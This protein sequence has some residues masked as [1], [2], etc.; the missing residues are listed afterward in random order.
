MDFYSVTVSAFVPGPGAE[1]TPDLDA[2][3][4]LG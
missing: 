3:A 1:T 2:I 4:F